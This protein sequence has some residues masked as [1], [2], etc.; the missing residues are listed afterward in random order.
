MERLHYPHPRYGLAPGAFPPVARGP[1][2]AAYGGSIAEPS[3]ETRHETMSTVRKLGVIAVMALTLSAPASSTAL[4]TSSGPRATP[5][6][7]A[8]TTRGGHTA[9]QG[10]LLVSQFTPI[11]ADVA[12][13]T[14]EPA[15]TSNP[16]KPFPQRI[17]RTTDAGQ[18][19]R[20]VTPAGLTV[21]TGDR[22]ISTADFLDADHAWVVHSGVADGSPQTL[23][24]TSDG[25]HHWSTIGR[26]PSPYC[27]VQFVN[28][29]DGWCVEVG[30]ASGE[31]EV[32]VY[33]TT[34]GGRRWALVSKSASPTGTPGSPGQP[35]PRMRQAA[36]VS[37]PEERVGWL[38]TATPGFRRSTRRPTEGTRGSDRP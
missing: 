27:E 22:Y 4:P 32:I 9:R 29:T 38:L 14:T 21:A 26:L 6:E 36:H 12:W 33:Q 7:A 11:G 15:A 18:S 2:C 35:A 16:S 24:S 19:W 23:V 13:A 28:A 8:S 31:D 37:H 3:K 5:P 17:I 25:G 10:A 1:L 30:A 20:D 34:D